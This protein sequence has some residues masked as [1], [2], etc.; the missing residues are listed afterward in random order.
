MD[1]LSSGAVKKELLDRMGDEGAVLSG[2][3]LGDKSA[4]DPEVKELYQKNGIAHLLAV[5]GLHVSFIG[6]LIYRTMRKAGVPFSEAPP[7]A[8][9]FC[10]RMQ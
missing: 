8:S 1:C 3:L 2:I 9:L 5:S 10:S 6:L 7:W 4:L